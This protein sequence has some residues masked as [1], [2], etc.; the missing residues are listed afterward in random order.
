[1]QL[2]YGERRERPVGLELGAEQNA[3]GL[4]PFDAQNVLEEPWRHVQHRNRL[5]RER[6]CGR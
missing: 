1:V 4:D 6:Q 3:A 5:A 2:P